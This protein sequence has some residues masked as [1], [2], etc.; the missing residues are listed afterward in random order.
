M[1]VEGRDVYR[2]YGDMGMSGMNSMEY[3]GDA[4]VGLNLG[5]GG[6]A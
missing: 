1:G 2:G 3:L 5:F 6:V 4:D